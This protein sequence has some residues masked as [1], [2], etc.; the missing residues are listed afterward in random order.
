MIKVS[1]LYPNLEGAVFNFDYYCNQ[2]MSMIKAKLGEAFRNI[3][4]ERGLI[5]ATAG[6]LPE[7]T[8][9]GYLYF[10]S[11]E[12]YR[13]AFGPHA[14]AIRDDIRNYTDIKPLVQVSD[15]LNIS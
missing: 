4:A 5:G 2:H 3:T 8:A 1:I 13:S 9:M 6:S 11:V 14:K 12:V 7:Y 10:E 15:I